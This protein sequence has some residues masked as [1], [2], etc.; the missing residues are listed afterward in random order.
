MQINR[1]LWLVFRQGSMLLV[2]L[3]A[4]AIAGGIGAGVVHLLTLVAGK[5]GYVLGM[6]ISVIV[7][8]RNFG[9]VVS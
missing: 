3:L 9:D 7:G 5:L 6:G 2:G 8:V 1:T 4:I